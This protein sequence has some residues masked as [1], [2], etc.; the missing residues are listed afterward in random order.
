MRAHLTVAG[1]EL[2]S[3]LLDCPLTRPSATLS[4]RTGERENF[5]YVQTPFGGCFNETAIYVLRRP[6]A[7]ENRRRKI[8]RLARSTHRGYQGDFTALRQYCSALGP[9]RF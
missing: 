6:S 2:G 8:S 4:P 5:G 3:P 1:T 9:R 7:I